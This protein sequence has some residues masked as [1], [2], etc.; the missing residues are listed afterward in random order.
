MA[1]IHILNVFLYQRIS[2]AC[3]VCR[4]K[5]PFARFFPGDESATCESKEVGIAQQGDVPWDKASKAAGASYATQHFSS[6][7]MGNRSE[8]SGLQMEQPEEWKS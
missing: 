8:L 6:R 7:Y 3:K 5:E 1:A 2:L 4:W